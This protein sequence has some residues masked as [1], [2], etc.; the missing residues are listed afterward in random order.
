MRQ[1][2]LVHRLII[3]GDKSKREDVVSTTYIV[4]ME[5]HE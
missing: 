3:I 2:D 5:M 4:V 1:L